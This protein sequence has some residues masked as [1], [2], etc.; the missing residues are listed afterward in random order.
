MK[1]TTTLLYL[2]LLFG[3]MIASC[4]PCDDGDSDENSTSLETQKI[5]SD[6]TSV[7]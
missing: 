4:T 6:T 5:Y 2:T 7:N 3:I 1:K